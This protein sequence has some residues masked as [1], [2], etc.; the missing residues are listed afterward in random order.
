M[1]GVSYQSHF[2]PIPLLSVRHLPLIS[3]LD[4]SYIPLKDNKSFL[5]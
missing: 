3:Y 5:E 2:Y 1:K 4:V